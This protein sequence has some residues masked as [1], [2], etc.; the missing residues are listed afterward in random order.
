MELVQKFSAL[1]L[2]GNNS[3]CLYIFFFFSKK[4]AK[5]LWYSG[6]QDNKIFIYG[7]ESEFIKFL[8]NL[9]RNVQK[10]YHIQCLI[11][12][13]QLIYMEFNIYKFYG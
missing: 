10:N 4:F 3:E 8:K 1:R 13:K 2:T 12:C 6:W 11:L 7:E 5:Y 9:T